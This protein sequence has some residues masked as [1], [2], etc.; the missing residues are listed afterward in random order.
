MPI[1]PAGFSL[2][3]EQWRAVFEACTPALNAFASTLFPRRKSMNNPNPNDPNKP[4]QPAPA[5]DPNRPNP[6]PQ[7][8]EGDREKGAA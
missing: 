7:P 4:G 5:P 2:T 3:P 6:A 1:P 8:G